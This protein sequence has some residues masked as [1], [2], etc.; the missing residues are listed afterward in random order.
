MLFTFFKNAAW[1]FFA[2]VIVQSSALS[3]TLEV[4]GNI[5]NATDPAKKSYL[6][7]DKQLLAMPVHSI[8]TSTSW[9]PQRKFEGVAVADILARVG[10]KAAR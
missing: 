6:F 4:T 9:T 3:F 2:L 5:E 10:P 1:A 8:T 7:T